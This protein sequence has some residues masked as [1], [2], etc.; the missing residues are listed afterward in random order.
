MTRTTTDALVRRRWPVERW[1]ADGYLNYQGV[2]W[3]S[4]SRSDYAKVLAPSGAMA[5]FWDSSQMGNWALG[6]PPFIAP[7]TYPFSIECAAGVLVTVGGPVNVAGNVA[8]H[9]AGCGTIYVATE[10]DDAYID[11]SPDSLWNLVWREKPVSPTA[12]PAP[13]HSSTQAR[14]ERLAL[15]Q[16]AFG[17]PLQKLSRVLRI[18][19]AQLYKWIDPQKEI[20]L[21]DMSRSRLTAIE[22]LAK[23]WLSLSVTP[24]DALDREMPTEGMTVLRL[25]SKRRLDEDAVAEAFRCLVESMVARPKTITQQMRE[26]GFKRRSTPRSLPSDE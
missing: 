18:S 25:L 19:R 4:V 1:S 3:P 7:V 2:C 16:A 23:L 11:A 17:F 8:A 9:R 14:T 20:Q 13:P 6:V 21:H 10:R 5:N 24:L 22:G 15:I 26:H 12:S